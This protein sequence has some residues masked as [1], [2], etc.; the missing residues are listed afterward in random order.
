LIGPGVWTWHFQIGDGVVVGNTKT[1]PMGMAARRVH[2]RIA[3]EA[4]Q[5]QI[6][7]RGRFAI[8]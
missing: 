8:R 3:I 6:S 5:I 2:Q 4:G 1:N 7:G